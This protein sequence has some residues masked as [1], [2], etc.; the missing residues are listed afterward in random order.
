MI[1]ASSCRRC[2]T[3]FKVSDNL[4]GKKAHCKKCGQSLRVPQT[5]AAVATGLFRMG[6][7]EAD[8]P[9]PRPDAQGV[10]KSTARTAAPA[11]L[12]LAP[13]PSLDDLK[14]VASKRERLWEDD[15][16]VE[17]ELEKPITK[18]ADTPVFEVAKQRVRLFWGR[19]GIAEVF[20]VTLRKF[21]LRYVCRCP[22]NW[23]TS[24]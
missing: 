24:T 21:D 6:A 3:R 7:V 10:L 4:A 23:T 11:S 14:P 2:A 19:G 12:R 18:P 9:S 20:L 22:F 15:D 8:R 5:P 17:Y 16:G 13:I 1:I